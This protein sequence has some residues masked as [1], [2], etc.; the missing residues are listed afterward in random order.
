MILVGYEKESSNYRLWDQLKRKIYISANVCFDEAN[1]PNQG[2][3][4]SDIPLKLVFENEVDV[5]QPSIDEIESVSYEDGENEYNAQENPIGENKYDLRDRCQIQPPKYFS[6]MIADVDIPTFYEQ[7]ITSEESDPLNIGL[8][9]RKS[10]DI[11]K[12]RKVLEYIYGRCEEFNGIDLCGYIVAYYAGDV[13]TR[14]LRTGYVFMINGSPVTWCSQRQQVVAL[15]TTETTAEQIKNPDTYIEETKNEKTGRTKK[16]LIA[17][18]SKPAQKNVNVPDTLEAPGSPNKQGGSAINPK[19][20]AKDLLEI[21]TRQKCNEIINLG[22]S[23]QSGN[24][25]ASPLSLNTLQ[26]DNDEPTWRTVRSKNTYKRNIGQS[27]NAGNFRGVKPKVWMYIY[28]V[29]KETE[30][31]DIKIF[32][33]EKTNEKLL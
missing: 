26:N 14:K 2:S 19:E 28:R 6:A 23:I 8:L 16:R 1:V 30:E 3:E 20:V 15:S 18:T 9:S 24:E 13:T 5:L 33:S 11:Y 21:Q 4:E 31:E 29:D 27:E 10:Q 22:G 17:N 7:A 32:I 12:V 25:T